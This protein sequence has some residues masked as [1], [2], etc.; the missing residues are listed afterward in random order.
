MKRSVV[1]AV[2]APRTELAPERFQH[3]HV[4]LARATGGGTTVA[5]ASSSATASDNQN[6]YFTG[7]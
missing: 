7:R 5:S 6:W 3:L 2:D 4:A 1:T